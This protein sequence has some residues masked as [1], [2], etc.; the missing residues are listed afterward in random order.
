MESQVLLKK[1]KNKVLNAAVVLLTLIIISNI[2]K[3]QSQQVKALNETRAAELKKN[4]ILSSISSLEKKISA[5]KKIFGKRD[6]SA[7]INSLSIIARES[8]VKIIS[9]TP[10]GQDNRSAYTKYPFDLVVGVENYHSLGKFVSNIESS[11]DL[12]FIDRMGVR[13]TEKSVTQEQKHGLTVNLSISTV[14]YR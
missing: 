5:F 4:E 6:P 13:P 7:V 14:S 3:G 8:N 12:F 11:N 9:I 10:K 1:Y 2:F